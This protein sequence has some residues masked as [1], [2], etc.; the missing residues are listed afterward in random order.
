MRTTVAG[1]LLI[2]GA[3]RGARATKAEEMQL[4]REIAAPGR[5][6]STDDRA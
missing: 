6:P 1:A 5:R 2:F 4:L 3:L